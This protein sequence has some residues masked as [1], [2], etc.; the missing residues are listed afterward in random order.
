MTVTNLTTGRPVRYINELEYIIDKKS[1]IPYIY[2]NK[3]LTNDILVIEPETGKIV[4]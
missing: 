2:A 4:R 1:G 3:Y